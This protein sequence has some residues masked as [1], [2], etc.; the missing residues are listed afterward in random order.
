MMDYQKVLELWGS[1]FGDENIVARRFEK[2]DFPDGDLVADFAEQVGIDASDFEVPSILNPSLD[3]PCVAFLREFIRH[4]PK[5]AD[6]QLSPLRGQVVPF[7]EEFRC[8]EPVKVPA[9]LAE[10]INETFLASNRIVSNK[11]FSGRFEP[12][13]SLAKSVAADVGGNGPNIDREL[14]IKI[15]AYLWNCQ[16]KIIVVQG[17]RNAFLRKTSAQNKVIG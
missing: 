6:R 4:V 13:F 7:L 9:S 17:Q 12:L 3:E 10:M 1:I 8:G 11:Y 5:V 15:A 14:L 2:A 16:Q